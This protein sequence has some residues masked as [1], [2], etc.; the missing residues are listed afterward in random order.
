MY[1]ADHDPIICAGAV[2]CGTCGAVGYPREAEWVSE[3]L[4]LATYE[5]PC[6][7][8]KSRTMV[9]DPASIPYTDQELAKYVR[10]RRCAGHNARGRPCR[11]YARPGSDFCRAHQAHPAARRAA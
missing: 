9:V 2:R 10:G 4:I 3:S 1:C 6:R 8:V 11:S 7:H 5:A